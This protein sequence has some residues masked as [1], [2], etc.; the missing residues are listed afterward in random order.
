MKLGLSFSGGGAR[1]IS[2]IGILKA[3]HEEGIEVAM[4]S[5]TSA[6]AIVGAFYCYGYSPDEIFDIVRSVKLFRHVRPA[7]N[8]SGL[9]K[10]DPTEA[11]YKR[12]LVENDFSALKI[13]LVI[14]ATNLRTGKVAYFAS[15]PLIPA[16]MAST[17]VPVIFN[18]VK[19]DGE[20][21]VDG[22]LLNNLPIEPLI[23]HVDKIIGVNCNPLS[24]NYKVGN[25]KSLLE[26]SLLLAINLNSY[27]KKEECDL[28]LE[29][30]ALKPFGGM[31]FNKAQFIFDIGYEY[32][33]KMMPEI[34]KLLA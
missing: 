14:P 7:I 6:G 5:G 11:I 29:A 20:C 22:G 4:I 19:I 3:L 21:Y 1:G 26:R 13:P 10:M 33:K 30:P 8:R 24:E 18:P 25:M 12:F 9:L 23:G 31:S 17:A 2:H 16:I 27:S 34:R 15:G 32:G 28:F